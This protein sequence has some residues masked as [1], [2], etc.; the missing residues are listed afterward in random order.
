MELTNELLD[1]YDTFCKEFC[2]YGVDSYRNQ[3][4]FT[5]N[6][7]IA[8]VGPILSGQFKDW[9]QDNFPACIVECTFCTGDIH[10]YSLNHVRK[11]LYDLSRSSKNS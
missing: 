6:N 11:G 3:A 5:K 8:L 2:S 10:I 9:I 4:F 7:E 1:E